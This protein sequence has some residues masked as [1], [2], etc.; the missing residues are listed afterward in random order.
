MFRAWI[1][2]FA[3]HHDSAATATPF[4]TSTT[5]ITPG[6]P[7]IDDR[8]TLAALPPKTGHVFTAAY[9]MFG[10]LKSIPKIARPL[11][12]SAV[13]TLGS[14]LPINFHSEAGF[15]GGFFGGVFLAASTARSA[16]GKERPLGAWTTRLCSARNAEAGAF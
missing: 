14:A 15:N 9:A 13:S 8:S 11:I 6:I 4:G 5:P 1:A 7:K 12:F 10:T 3:C 16:N 2:A